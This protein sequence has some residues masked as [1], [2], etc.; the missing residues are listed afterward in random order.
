MTCVQS[1]TWTQ[2]TKSWFYMVIGSRSQKVKNK[3]WRLRCHWMYRIHWI[4]KSPNQWIPQIFLEK[5]GKAIWLV[6]WNMTFI[7][8]LILGMS[9]SQLISYFSEGWAQPPTSHWFCETSA[10]SWHPAWL[11]PQLEGSCSSAA[12]RTRYS[13]RFIIFYPFGNGSMA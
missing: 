9:S 10:K 2:A 1:C 12:R 11:S 4:G 8:P 5:L 3:D 6:V 13:H 7:F